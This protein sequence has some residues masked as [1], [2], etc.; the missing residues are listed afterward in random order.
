MGHSVLLLDMLI[1]FG[2]KHK[3]GLALV[4]LA[5]KLGSTMDR[6][7]MIAKFPLGDKPLVTARLLTRDW[8]L[9]LVHKSHVRCKML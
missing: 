8:S 2:C 9:F 7:E 4:L 6:A 3:G 5:S 1:I